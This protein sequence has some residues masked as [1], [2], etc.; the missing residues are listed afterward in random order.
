MPMRNA[1]TPA[2]L[3]IIL[4]LGTGHA[5]RAA[6]PYPSSPIKM[7]V[8]LAAGGPSDLLARTV[9]QGLAKELS[10]TIVVENKPGAGGIVA[11]SSV[12]Q[13]PADGH[14]IEFAAMP[15]MVFVPLLNSN[16]P[17]VRERD[18]TPVGLIASYDLY[19]LCNPALPVANLADLVALA[20][21][22]PGELTFGSGGVGTS[23]HLAGELMKRMAG[24]EIT[25]VP[26]KGNVLAQQ[27]V[28]AG[29][30]PMMFDFLSTTRQLVETGK[31]RMLAATGG[32]R[33]RFVPQT[34]TLDEEGLK[35]FELSAWFGL[36]VRAGTPGAVVQEL[37]AALR[38][39]LA[40]DDMVRQLTAQGYDIVTSS[41][42]EMATRIE[43]DLARWAPVIRAGGIK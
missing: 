42:A 39:A 37:N 38:S 13:S 41:P 19:L 43:T 28:I 11:A 14:T 8:G 1:A 29:R 35:G 33:S 34:P 25:H 15:A 5:S 7:V 22:R 23:N 3:A 21:S 18:L 6:D 30:V 16:L 20:R 36:S 26:Y 27:D 12:A 9:A 17:Y 40:T 32:K 10:A 4:S 2:L 24:I 31:L